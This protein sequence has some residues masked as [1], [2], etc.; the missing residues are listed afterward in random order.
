MRLGLLAYA[1]KTGLGFQTK[2]YYKHFKPE[3]VML[4]DLSSLNNM[5]IDK[6]WYEDAHYVRGYPLNEQIDSF[7]DGLDVM[8]FAETPLNY[9]FYK[10]ARELGIKTINVVNPEF[11]EH[12]KYPQFE[13]PDVI[14]LPSVWKEKE[15]RHHAES[16]G[17]K[18]VQLHHPVDRDEIHFKLRTTVKPL[19]IAGKPA[20]NDRNGTWDFLQACPN[21]VVTVQ[22]QRLAQ[23]IKRRYRNSRVLENINDQNWMYQTG[24]IFVMPRKYGGNCL[25]LNE[26][27]ASGMPV[28]MTDIEPNNHILPKEWLVPA[29]KVGEFYPRTKVDIYQAN[30]DILRER[31]AYFTQSNIQEESR[32]ASDIADTISWTTLKS[33]WEEAIYEI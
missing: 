26:A 16:K 19:H 18:V 20:A 11:Y 2:S 17:T 10:R 28:I 5:T 14:I 33:K 9:H 30:P 1:S 32:R 27:L 24:D 3:K 12:T 31:I 8:L 21:G 23:H 22:D 4:V 15:I 25:P 7:L 13:L 6:T 29:V